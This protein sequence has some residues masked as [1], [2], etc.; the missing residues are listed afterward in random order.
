MLNPPNRRI[1][2]RTYGGVGGE[3]PR[4]SP[5]SRLTVASTAPVWI[6]TAPQRG[7]TGKHERYDADAAGARPAAAMDRGGRPLRRR[8]ASPGCRDRLRARQPLRLP[9][10]RRGG[11]PGLRHRADDLATPQFLPAP[12]L[13]ERPCAARALREMRRQEDLR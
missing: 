11:L 7:C 3:E 9:D 13:S 5:L 1:R 12:S 4:G 2:T 6:R 8:G 10:L